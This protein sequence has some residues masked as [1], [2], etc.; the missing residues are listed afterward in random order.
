[1]KEKNCRMNTSALTKNLDCSGF[2]CLGADVRCVSVPTKRCGQRDVVAPPK[3]PQRTRGC[4]QIDV[5]ES[6]KPTLD[7]NIG[8]I[9]YSSWL[10]C[11]W[12]NHKLQDNYFQVLSYSP[13]AGHPPH[14]EWRIFGNLVLSPLQGNKMGL[15]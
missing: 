4:C 12:P 9:Q 3:M 14:R 5:H 10:K 1:M 7:V 15:R 13:E 8:L 11:I 2:K 6:L